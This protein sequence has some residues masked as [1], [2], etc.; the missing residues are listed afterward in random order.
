MQFEANVMFNGERFD[1]RLE[2]GT[3]F[4]RVTG[5]VS[6]TPLSCRMAANGCASRSM[7]RSA[8]ISRSWTL[9]SKTG[10]STKMQRL[11]TKAKR[12]NRKEET[13]VL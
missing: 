12:K 10:N 7:P 9:M 4:T 5:T 8:T 6:A 11:F 13:N 1:F 2:D 3:L